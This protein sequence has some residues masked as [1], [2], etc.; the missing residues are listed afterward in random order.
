[1]A[2]IRTLSSLAVALA[3]LT[4]L[5]ADVPPD[6]IHY[7][8]VLRDAA[9]APSTGSFD[10][11]FRFF[12]APVGGDEIM[13]DRHL[14]VDGTHV[15]VTTGQFSV[16]IGSGEILDGSGPGDYTTL[17][18]TF[19][20]HGD[21]WLDIQVGVETLAPRLRLAS[22]GYALNARTFAGRET[23]E[24]IDT[25][26]EEQTKA[27]QLNLLGAPLGEYQPALTAVGFIGAQISSIFGPSVL[28]GNQDEG[29]SASGIGA[30][31]GFH[32]YGGVGVRAYGSVRGGH[33]EDTD[34]PSSV[35]LADGEIGAYI[36]GQYTGAVV[37][38]PASLSWVTLA[39]GFLGVTASGQEPGEANSFS[40][41]GMFDLRDAT[42]EST[43]TARLAYVE[44]DAE[45]TLDFVAGGMFE[46][47]VLNPTAQ[48][49]I[50][51]LPDFGVGVEA[52]GVFSGGLFGGYAEIGSR[53]LTT[54]YGIRAFGTIPG[55]FTS[56][57]SA[58]WVDVAKS[59][60][61]IQGPGSVAFVQN[62]PH[63]KD[64]VIVYN[65]PEGAEV[66]TY[67]RGSA[68]LVGGEA[69]IRLEETFAWVTNPD[70]G[71]TAHLT[72]RGE[73]I[74]L[75][76]ESLTTKE[77]VVRAPA[78]APPGLEFD[79]LVYGLRI[80]FEETSIVREKER[81]AH[82]PSMAE[83]RKL[84]ADHPELR[85]FNALERVKGER[86]EMGFESAPN[87][88]ASTALR[89]AIH[90]YDPAVDGPIDV[91][92]RARLSHRLAAA[93]A[94][95]PAPAVDRRATALATAPTRGNAPVDAGGGEP[96][97]QRRS[98]PSP[99]SSPLPPAPAGVEGGT[100]LLPVGGAVEAGDVLVFDPDEPG[101]LRRGAA[102]AE[103]GTVGIA[104]TPASG[105]EGAL[106]PIAIMGL[107]TCKV[108]AGYGAIRAG[109]LLT[110]SPTL[111][112]AMR[113]LEP[114]PGTILGM[115]AETLESGTGVIKVLVMP[116]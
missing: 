37:E 92:E 64:R 7:Q 113:A 74:P 60:Y 71:L 18:E 28:L 29:V 101:R 21:L 45:A 56:D 96:A 16:E 89:D 55:S 1:V 2:A 41:A 77:L 90:E 116:R 44:T 58:G 15:V 93:A 26:G 84:Y 38:T 75:A 43:T 54:A 49:A 98:Q 94:G 104:A 51:E 76:V 11:I 59:S 97:P 63:E 57:S 35:E 78:D 65:A 17:R 4:P 10:M 14:L 61:K 5:R 8:G 68:R 66:A 107:V 19:R 83:H 46:T 47:G 91:P 87:M 12:D 105:P 100:V 3:A 30:G 34:N 32:S 85:R 50:M 115:A 99:T 81:E 9:G 72:P 24:F 95:P 62:H 86:R 13:M 82:I 114:I 40:W 33:F 22:A 39:N 112:H 111:G 42:Q 25:S 109:D 53:V 6:L 23:D 70:L 48:L 106:V 31:G 67:A 110:T 102:I 69:R 36:R 20:D 80:G 103:P 52:G 79:Y 73:P 108:D 27:G 88:T